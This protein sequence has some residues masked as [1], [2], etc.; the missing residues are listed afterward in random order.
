MSNQRQIANHNFI[1]LQEQNPQ[2]QNQNI[3]I[4]QMPRVIYVDSTNFKTSPCNTV[5]PFCHNQIQ[6][7][8]NTKCNWYSCLLCYFTGCCYWALFQWCRNKNLNCCDA[9]HFC[10]VCGNK[11]VDYTSC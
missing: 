1:P 8:I 11:I 6:T 4:N 9:E 10:P 3:I 7:K 5:C 2:I